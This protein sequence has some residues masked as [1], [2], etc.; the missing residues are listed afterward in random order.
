MVPLHT[1]HN[2]L[3]VANSFFDLL[4][5]WELSPYILVS[6]FF[7]LMGYCLGRSRLINRI[8]YPIVFRG[9]MRWMCLLAYLTALGTL[10]LALVSPISRYSTDLFFVHMIQHMLL[11]MVAAPLLLLSDPMALYLWGMPQ[12]ARHWL[13]RMV[14]PS[15]L[16]RQLIKAMTVPVIAWLL[17]VVTIAV[18]HTPV[19][20]NAALSRDYLH[21]FEHISMFGVAILFWW[22]VIGSAP[23]RS[24]L[25]YP[26]RFLYLFMALF[27]NIILG[28]ILTFGNGP[29]YSYYEGAPNHWGITPDF[30]QQLGGIIMWIPGS[31]MFF[32]VISILLFIWLEQEETRNI[33]YRRDEETRRRFLHAKLTSK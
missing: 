30:D 19:A 31:M 12:S 10:V 23:L 15:G 26:L 4:G 25:P 32:G 27:Q 8:K 24:S 9:P 20:Y 13:G 5:Y 28:A 14:R 1:G 2:H 22:P 18:W 21:A 7:V 16:P 11:I 3:P 17:F 6:L 33:K 29:V